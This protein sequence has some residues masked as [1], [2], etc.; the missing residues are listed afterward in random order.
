MFGTIM[1]EEVF[2]VG[3]RTNGFEVKM[4]NERFTFVG[5]KSQLPRFCFAEYVQ[6]IY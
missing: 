1:M 2:Y 6:R 4:D 3:I 5:S